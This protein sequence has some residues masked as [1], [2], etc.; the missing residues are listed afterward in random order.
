MNSHEQGPNEVTRLHC[1]RGKKQVCLPCVEI[2]EEGLEFSEVAK[3]L[4]PAEFLRTQREKFEAAR[5]RAITSKHGKMRKAHLRV[6]RLDLKAL[7]AKTRRKLVRRKKRCQMKEFLA[8]VR[9][10]ADEGYSTRQLMSSLIPGIGT[11]VKV[12]DSEVT[13]ALKD[14]QV[15]SRGQGR[16]LVNCF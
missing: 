4:I 14:T 12:A 1:L 15:A 8:E 10:R 9:S 6:Q 7:R 5:L 13:A 16:G 11:E 2:D 3:G